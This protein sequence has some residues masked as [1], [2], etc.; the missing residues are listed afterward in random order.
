[1]AEAV[2]HELKRKQPMLVL[3]DGGT[4]SLCSAIGIELL[5]TTEW[6]TFICYKTTNGAVEQNEAKFSLSRQPFRTMELCLIS[7]HSLSPAVLSTDQ[8]HRRRLHVVLVSFS[9]WSRDLQRWRV[10]VSRLSFEQVRVRFFSKNLNATCT[11]H[12]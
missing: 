3:C 11:L 6:A 12:T 1:M 7:S 4:R 2:R 8:I 10:Q 9:I 5:K